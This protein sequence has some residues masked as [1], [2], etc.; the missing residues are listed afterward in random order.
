[1]IVNSAIGVRSVHLMN[2]Q[3]S[4]KKVPCNRIESIK[5]GPGI[6]TLS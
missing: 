5:L 6:A 1:M 2:K 4:K 3:T